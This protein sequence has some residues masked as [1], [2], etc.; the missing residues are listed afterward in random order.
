MKHFRAAN[1]N[2][3]DGLGNGNGE[4][5]AL[6]EELLRQNN[7]NEIETTLNSNN[8]SD[9][10]KN[11]TNVAA[12][13]HLDNLAFE[14]FNQDDYEDE[15]EEN[16]FE[17]YDDYNRNDYADVDEDELGYFNINK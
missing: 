9:E 1:N 13:K 2:G 3:M 10:K 12:Y 6:E 7:L 14:D 8:E 5:N 4:E 11:K 17:N 15:N 16:R